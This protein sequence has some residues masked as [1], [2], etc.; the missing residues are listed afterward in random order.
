MVKLT[1]IFNY[2]KVFLWLLSFWRFIRIPLVAST[3]LLGLLV[4]YLQHNHRT[5]LAATVYHILKICIIIIFTAQTI[6]VIHNWII[7]Q[8]QSEGALTIYREAQRVQKKVTKFKKQ[9]ELI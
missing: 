4:L 7:L 6:Y 5:A 8:T 1:D 3:A 9:E 2:Y